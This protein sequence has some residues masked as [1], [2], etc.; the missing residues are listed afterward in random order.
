[1]GGVGALIF[2][3]ALR[4][5]PDNTKKKRQTIR[6]FI[7]MALGLKSLQLLSLFKN[8]NTFTKSFIKIVLTQTIVTHK[9]IDV[10]KNIGC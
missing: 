7:F 8:K 9:N 10:I 4:T 2:V 6:R 5:S 1:M 3:C